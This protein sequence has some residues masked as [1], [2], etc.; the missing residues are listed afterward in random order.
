MNKT[1]EEQIL[2][3]L[4]SLISKRSDCNT[5]AGL[6]NQHPDTVSTACSNLYYQ[7]LISYCGYRE[8]QKCELS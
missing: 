1:L 3:V 2:D 6:L 8:V 5:L 7:G 4:D